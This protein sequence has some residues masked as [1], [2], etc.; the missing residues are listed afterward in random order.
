MSFDNFF[1][2]I[3][4]TG[5]VTMKALRSIFLL[6]CVV[7]FFGCRRDAPDLFTE[8]PK[9]G[10]NQNGGGNGGGNDNGGGGSTPI[11]TPKEEIA[12]NAAQTNDW[13]TLK[14]EIDSKKLDVFNFKSPSTGKTLIEV[15]IESGSLDVFNKL[16]ELEPNLIYGNVLHLILTS[17]L[18]SN[19][20][21]ELLV[22]KI[23]VGEVSQDTI[24]SAL[25]TTIEEGI[26]N[27]R[28]SPDYLTLE[29]LIKE[30]GADVFIT[31]FYKV[32]QGESGVVKVFGINLLY[33]A[34]GCQSY[35]IEWYEDEDNEGNIDYVFDF[36][37]IL[38]GGVIKPSF[39]ELLIRL[40]AD[41]TQK[42][43]FFE[44]ELTFVDFL[45]EFEDDFKV[46]EFELIERAIEESVPP[47]FK[48]LGCTQKVDSEADKYCLYDSKITTDQIQQF[49]ELVEKGSD[50]SYQFRV[51]IFGDDVEEVEVSDLVRRLN[52]FVIDPRDPDD[53]NDD[54]KAVDDAQLRQVLT[55]IKQY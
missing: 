49:L 14:R 18:F 24:D 51:S 6:C 15:A 4:R 42:A 16:I 46:E 47:L 11:E 19:E 1:N 31:D 13:D 9:G 5:I 35:T 28:G 48:V 12:F 21:K 29:S 22:Q 23:T 32:P 53:K 36:A 20:E 27:G 26:D 37:E 2:K 45:A 33:K 25:V 54:I 3:K 17:S 7:A 40:G 39:I 8:V 52:N 10:A 43:Y 34:L 44:E 41:Y 50:Y 55:H 30:E 38:C